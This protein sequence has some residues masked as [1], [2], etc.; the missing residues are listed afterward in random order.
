MPSKNDIPYFSKV[1]GSVY[2]SRDLIKLV[3]LAS[4]LRTLLSKMP[5]AFPE[6][7]GSEFTMTTEDTAAGFIRTKGNANSTHY[8]FCTIGAIVNTVKN[9]NI[10]SKIIAKLVLILLS[11]WKWSWVPPDIQGLNTENPCSLEDLSV[12]QL[13][14]MY[15]DLHRAYCCIFHFCIV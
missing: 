8:C 5:F 1:I 14:K 12:S 13:N 9:V 3:F 6:S 7:S 4:S 11:P 2:K 15:K 10:I